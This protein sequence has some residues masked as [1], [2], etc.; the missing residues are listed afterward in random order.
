MPQGS[1]L[2]SVLFLWHRNDL[3]LNIQVAKMVSLPVDTN[4]LVIDK[5]WDVL[6]PK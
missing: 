4:I 5:N 3:P 1:V 2:E 6:Q